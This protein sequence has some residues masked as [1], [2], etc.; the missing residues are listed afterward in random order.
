MFITKSKFKFIYLEITKNCN[1]KCPFCPS[2]KISNN[3]YVSINS[4]SEMINKIKEYT[5]TVYLHV[6]GEPLLHPNFEELVK[7]CNQ[8]NLLVRLTTNGTLLY[9][10]DFSK[11]ELNKINIS[12]QSLINLNE[13]KQSVYFKNLENFLVQVKD[14]LETGRLGIAL[15]LWNDKSNIMIKKQNE[16]IIEILENTI[17]YK[18]YKNVKIDEEDEFEW[19]TIEKVDNDNKYYCHGGSTH[20]AILTNGDVVLCCLDYSGKTKL[21]N[22]YNQSLDTILNSDPYKMIKNSNDLYFDL[23]KKCTYRNKFIKTKA[24]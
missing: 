15:R 3:E 9:K 19:P 14:K 20:I 21:G 7:I 6:L 16:R 18:N 22:I 2:S 5:K 4:F 17:C 11:L 23:C 8:S 1:L 12:L 13:E 10:Y 24:R